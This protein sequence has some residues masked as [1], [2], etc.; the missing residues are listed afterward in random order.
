MSV[1]HRQSI[2]HRR[3]TAVRPR[4]RQR[5]RH[6]KHALGRGAA[7]RSRTP[8][9]WLEGLAAQDWSRR[10]PL[11]DRDL[12]RVLVLVGVVALAAGL[13]AADALAGWAK[14]SGDLPSAL[15]CTVLVAGLLAA[16]AVPVRGELRRRRAR[17]R[18]G[19]G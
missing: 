11:S 8:L 16:A 3:P 2:G 1:A 12:L 9:A 14:T 4:G 15:L 13:L 19:V 5:L 7:E 18:D 17:V 6:V 10:R